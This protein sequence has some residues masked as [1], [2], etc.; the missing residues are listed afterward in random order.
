MMQ[1]LKR[2]QNAQDMRRV[3]NIEKSEEGKIEDDEE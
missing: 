1:Q 3:N 2:R